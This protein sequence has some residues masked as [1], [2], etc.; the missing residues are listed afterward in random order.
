[1]VYTGRLVVI[2]MTGQNPF[3]GFV[4][5]SKTHNRRR[6]ELRVCD[7][8]FKVYVLP[9]PGFEKD[10]IEH[11]DVDNY[12]CLIAGKV[13][14]LPEE[15]RYRIVGFNGHMCKRC[16]ANLED[17]MKPEIAI[18]ST[19]FEFRGAPGDAR[20]GGIVYKKN[21]KPMGIIGINDSDRIE[22]RIKAYELIDGKGIYTCIK[23]TGRDSYIKLPEITDSNELASYISNNMMEGL[24]HVIASGV[25][26]LK[27]N[28]FEI[29]VY[30]KPN[31]LNS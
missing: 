27:G 4:L 30:N 1:M 14:F 29:G 26:I 5:A 9:Q 22:K 11:P 31:N 23:D 17:G 7:N 18:D 21:N 15:E 6:M 24:E 20:V 13:P 16:M 2:G 10:N 8:K 28:Q 19:L 12:A 25:C 3:M